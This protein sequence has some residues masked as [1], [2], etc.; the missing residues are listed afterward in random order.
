[1]AVKVRARMR[2]VA[3]LA[4]VG[5]MTVS[6]VIRGNVPV[7][8]EARARVLAAIAKLD[9]RPN[10]VARSLREARTRSIGIIVPNFYDTFFASCAHAVSQV[11][12][13][14]GYSVMV[15]T[16]AEDAAVEYREA[17][18]MVR[19]NI[20]GL[21]VIPAWF[22][23]TQLVRPEF[24]SVPMVTLD[25]PFTPSGGDFAFRGSV[26]VDNLTSARRGVEHLIEHG[27]RR[28][29]YLS[30]SNDLYTLKERHAGYEQC[31]RD[32]GLTPEGYFTCAT[33]ESTLAVLK[34]LHAEGRMPT[35]IF[36]SNNLVTQHALHALA[37][38]QLS[39]PQD[40]A[41][42]GFDDLQ[43]FDIF[44]PP[45]TVI[46]Q[47]LEELGRVAAEMLLEHLQSPDHARTSASERCSVVL[48]VELVVRRSCGCTAE[49]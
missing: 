22:G 11:A 8:E 1:M 46:R 6:R 13:K 25:R 42:V 14:R 15:T 5:T 38:L 47:P 49:R 33:Q 45:I 35:A 37:T 26:M 2:D 9:Y 43:M 31:M 48:P 39:I 28:I 44:I 10:E 30:L 27:H 24:A 41:V 18:L 7:S 12:Q 21:V 32:A 19:R 34:T 4:G 3:E 16:S 17:S 23:A 40:V 36:S 20:E 29:L